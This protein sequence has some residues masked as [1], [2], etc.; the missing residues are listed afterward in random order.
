MNDP[1]ARRVRRLPETT[2]GRIT[3]DLFYFAITAAALPFTIVEAAVGSGSTIMVEAR[4][5]P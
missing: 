3:R 2:A 1:M 4:R 5:R